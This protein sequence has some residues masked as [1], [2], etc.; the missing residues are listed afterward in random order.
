[1]SHLLFLQEQK[2]LL[3]PKIIFLY[4][5]VLLTMSWCWSVKLIFLSMQCVLSLNNFK[6]T[7][8]F[9]NASLNYSFYVS[10]ISFAFIFYLQGLLCFLSWNIYIYTYLHKT[11]MY[12]YAIYIHLYVCIYTCTYFIYIYIPI[13]NTWIYITS[14]SFNVFFL[15]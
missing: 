6:T 1:M 7:F 15:S 9:R 12:M 5:V 4:P 8:Q 11:Y 3:I 14:I 2:A 10:L 13:E